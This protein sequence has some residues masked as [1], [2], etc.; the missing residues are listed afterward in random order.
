MWIIWEKLH[1]AE[2]AEDAEKDLL[3]VLRPW[4]RVSNLQLHISR[5]EVPVD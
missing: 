1:T 3:R 2:D 5:R 4:W